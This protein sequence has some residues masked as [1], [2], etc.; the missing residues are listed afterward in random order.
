MSSSK[1]DKSIADDTEAACLLVSSDGKPAF[2]HP[3]VLT[4]AI[5]IT[6]HTTDLPVSWRPTPDTEGS[7]HLPILIGLDG[8]LRNP[9][10]T[11]S[12]PNC[13][14]FPSLLLTLTD[15]PVTAIAE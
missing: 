6:F 11:R 1:C 14:L 7:D 10:R 9:T 2:L 8:G 3:K 13:N 4:S 5:N 15:D 12:V